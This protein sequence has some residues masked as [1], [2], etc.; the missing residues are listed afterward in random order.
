MCIPVF[1]NQDGGS[2]GTW[3][4]T[5]SSSAGQTATLDHVRL[6]LRVLMVLGSFHGKVRETER[7]VIIP[8]TF[9]NEEM[10][11]FTSD[12]TSALGPTQRI[13]TRNYSQDLR[14]ITVLGVL[15]I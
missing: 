1:F 8:A 5:V 14:Q 6:R 13:L 3:I 2:N 10:L 15:T 4:T 12:N 11:W 7:I 9:G